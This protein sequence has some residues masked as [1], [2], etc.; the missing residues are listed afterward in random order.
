[1]LFYFDLYSFQQYKLH[2]NED[3]HR[4]GFHATSS[5]LQIKSII[6]L[7]EIPGRNNMMEKSDEI[8]LD[9]PLFAVAN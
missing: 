7:V 8:D 2:K 6:E 1:M 4:W 9:H 3:H 5:L